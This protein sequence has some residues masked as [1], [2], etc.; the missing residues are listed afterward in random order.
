MDNIGPPPDPVL[1]NAEI[2]ALKKDH[3]ILHAAPYILLV[4]YLE[5]NPWLRQELG[6]QREIHS[7][8]QERAQVLHMILT[9]LMI[10]TT[11]NY[12]DEV[13]KRLVGG[14][15][16][17][18]G[19]KIFDHYGP[20]GFYIY[21]FFDIHRDFHPYLS[22]CLELGR[23]FIVEDYQ[24]KTLPLYLLWKGILAFMVKN[25]QYNT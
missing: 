3:I 11:V 24:K 15:R 12:C 25:Q 21:C 5:G 6:R 13:T 20:E 23:S 10:I 9:G 18:C 16:F 7:G 22:Q 17:G 19:D 4:C 8:R 2:E 1:L 14:Y